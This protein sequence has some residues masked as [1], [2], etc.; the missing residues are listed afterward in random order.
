MH[1]SRLLAALRTIELIAWPY[2]GRIAIAERGRDLEE[3]HVIDRWQYLGT[4][5][6]PSMAPFLE[7]PEPGFDRDGYKILVK[8]IFSGRYEILPIG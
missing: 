4:V 5:P 3:F 7:H 1:S 6:T 2:P 8:P